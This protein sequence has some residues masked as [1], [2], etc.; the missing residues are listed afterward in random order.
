[1]VFSS[2]VFIWVFLPPVLLIYH[3]CGRKLRNIV[4]LMSS[5]VFYAW[6]EPVYI[7][8]MIFSILINYIAG[9]L[10]D[11][12]RGDSFRKKLILA[13]DIVINLLL[14]GYYKYFNFFVDIINNLFRSSLKNRDISLPI[15]ISFFT[16]Q[17]LSYIIDLYRDK[18]EVQRDP[19]KLALYISFFPQLIAGPI[20]QYD[21][22]RRQLDHRTESFEKAASGIKRFI[23][24]LAK[25]VLIANTMAR[26]VDTV[27]EANSAYSGMIIWLATVA[28]A[29]QI[30]YDFSGYSDMAIGLGKMFG[31]EFRENFNYPYMSS[32]IH[33][34]WQRW[35][36][37]LGAWFREYL[38]FPL[39]GNRKGR[40]RTYIN[41]MIV[42]LLTG[43]WHGASMTFVLWG[44][45]HVL[46]QIMERA[47]FDSVLNRHRIFAHCYSLIVVIFG[48]VLFRADTI[49]QVLEIVTQML[50]PWKYTHTSAILQ[51]VLTHRF[52]V[53]FILGVAGMGL[54]QKPLK[55]ITV[56]ISTVLVNIFE[57]SYCMLILLLSM[58]SLAGNTY[59]PFIYFRF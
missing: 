5:L 19:L 16:F 36:I 43:L 59:N 38:Y 58:A 18:Y 39:G 10:I 33:E 6:G 31:F 41:L 17:I 53:M 27:Y 47:G 12:F 40:V 46:F 37:S 42:F 7:F 44:L 29:L 11:R 34:F 25:K 4:L 26:F 14:L 22:I 56:S 9:L 49:A 3:L 15:G 48:W 32:S 51:E 20:V 21:S 50:L 57:Y 8:L 54:L 35:H 24:G 13:A 45:F 1:M 55:R 2:P 30:Y 28:Y 52:I 23:Y